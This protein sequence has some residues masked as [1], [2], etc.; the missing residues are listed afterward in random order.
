MSCIFL[1]FVFV[2]PPSLYIAVL[3]TSPSL[4]RWS[5][6]WMLSLLKLFNLWPSSE[7]V[8]LVLFIL[9]T[10]LTIIFYLLEM[11]VVLLSKKKT[12]VCFVSIIIANL[13]HPIVSLSSKLSKTKIITVPSVTCQALFFPRVWY[14]KIEFIYPNISCR[15]ASVFVS[16]SERRQYYYEQTQEKN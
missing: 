14:F 8:T 3:T 7:Y 1:R 15:Y 6:D 10:T 12:S 5:F 2:P 9:L 11:F 16:L 13:L 4:S